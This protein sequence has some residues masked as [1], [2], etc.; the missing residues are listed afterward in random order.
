MSAG[1]GQFFQSYAEGLLRIPA[2]T[3]P[4]IRQPCRDRGKPFPG[5]R[6]CSPGEVQA[7]GRWNERQPRASE[8]SVRGDHFG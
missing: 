8:S 3:T 4:G 5:R 1:R 7:G 2:Q 6:C